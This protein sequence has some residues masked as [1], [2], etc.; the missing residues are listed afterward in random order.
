MR[1]PS[2]SVLPAG[3]TRALTPSRYRSLRAYRERQFR[4]E[5]KDYCPA[6]S[7]PVPPW[8]DR[9][10]L[11]C[12]KCLGELE[13]GCEY[14]LGGRVGRFGRKLYHPACWKIPP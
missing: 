13:V 2:S 9:E 8:V 4:A 7:T 14:T 5:E 12:A 11:R 3:T 6:R 10:R 1:S